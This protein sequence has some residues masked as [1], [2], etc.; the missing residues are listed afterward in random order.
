MK[1]VHT[2][3]PTWAE[4]DLDR[5]SQN[6]R[7]V[8]AFCGEDIK[9]MAVIKADA[10]GHGAAECGK[11]L[12]A[13]GVD[14][15]GVACLEEAVEL[16]KVGITRPILVFGGAWPGQEIAF[17]NFDLTPMVF[18]IQQAARLNNAAAAAKK[19]VAIHVK[20][21]TGMNRVGFRPEDVEEAAR[22]MADMTNIRI[23]GL[24]TH[25]AVADKLEESAFTNDQISKFAAAVDIFLRAGHRPEFIDLA[26]S[27][28]AIV[29]P[30]SRSKMVRIGGLLFGITGD[31]IP[32]DTDQ[33]SLEP[34]MSIYTEVAMLKTVP[35]CENIGYG[36]TFTASCDS[37]I[38]TVPIGYN[39]GYD[40]ALSN[41]GEM[42]V[43]G[44]LVP[45]VGRVSM[46]WVTIDVTDVPAVEVGD[47]VTV[48]GSD[49]GAAVT[50]EGIA[51]KI[52]TISYEFTCG[53]S[54]RVPRIYK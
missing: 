43:R 51:R 4:I 6:F 34:I 53:I 25:F 40:R 35:K 54:S 39:D 17:S 1:A 8:K 29:Y 10:Y 11:R 47:R 49:G 7:S 3:R 44:Q 14:W 21:D 36:R 28:G 20:V 41:A 12:E 9:Y 30:H 52:D 13:E 45:V 32:Q 23:E 18:T 48:L 31:V 37:L 22:M 27:P 15:L 5:L 19:S 38:A 46:D 33:P 42:I 24:M 50:A 26:N 2:C 16:R